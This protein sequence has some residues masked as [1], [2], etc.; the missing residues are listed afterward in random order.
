[1]SMVPVR[2]L[3]ECDLIT[4]ALRGD[5]DAFAAM[6]TRHRSGVIRVARR[7]LGDA[8][9]A[10]D[11]AQETFVRAYRALTTFDRARPLGPWLYRIATNLSL[12]RLKR[13][14]VAADAELDGQ[15]IELADSA[16]NPEGAFL[17]KEVR[18]RLRKEVAALPDHY[19]LVIELRH[20]RDLSY[21]EIADELGVP[22]SDVKSWLF[23]ARKRLRQ[24][25]ND[26]RVR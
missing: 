23:R 22:L 15:F 10:E 20:Y 18:N 4:L 3:T 24:K 16:P 2:E 14:S 11:V 7:L 25:L 5:A 12:N 19:R 1:M 8:H 9:E 26:V 6:V 21:Q 13:R 17:R